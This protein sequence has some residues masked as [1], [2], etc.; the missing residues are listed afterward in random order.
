VRVLIAGADGQIGRALREAVP[1]GVEAL[2]LNFGELDVTNH[3]QVTGTVGAFGPHLVINASGY[4][5]VDRS[6]TEPEAA[7]AVN[8]EGAGRLARAARDVGAR[9]VHYSTDYVFDGGQDRPYLPT[10]IPHPLSVYGRSK[11][12]GEH[13][14]L[15]AL[16]GRS[17]V[18]RT[19]WVYAPWGRNF[20]L[21]ML[22]LMEERDRVRVVSDQIGTPTCAAS[23]AAATWAIAGNSAVRGVVHWTDDGVCTWHEFA[24]V[25]RE[26]GVAA[27]LLEHPAEILAIPTSDYPTPACR[28]RYSVLDCSATRSVLGM[29]PDHWRVALRRTIRELAHG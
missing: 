27:G 13:A 14:V 2:A 10:D 18:V 26:E 3:A 6:E 7:H 15:E 19:A 21:T 20:L 24:V 5:A 17:V 12:A 1:P 22:R 28:P 23:V 9:M 4:T 16:P 8:A 29:V 25:I 11:L